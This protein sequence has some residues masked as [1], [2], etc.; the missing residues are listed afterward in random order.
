MMKDFKI[1]AA[2]L[3]A[4]R[5]PLRDSVHTETFITIINQRLNQPNNLA[6]YVLGNNLNRRRASF[7]SITGN[8]PNL[9]DFPSL[10]EDDLICFALGTYQVKLARSYY[11]EHVRQGLYNI[12]VFRDPD[13]TGLAEYGITA[14]NVW[15]LRC[16][17]QSRHARSRIYYS[18]ILIDRQRN[19]REAIENYYCSCLSGK[20][21]LGC[22]AHIMSIVW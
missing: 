9:S 5:E 18:Y 16:R 21:T 12:E 10:T 6:E 8:Q 17:I 15:L 3:N 13:C 7:D 4:R 11:A 19:C 1:A 14:T 2:L 22:C 20:R